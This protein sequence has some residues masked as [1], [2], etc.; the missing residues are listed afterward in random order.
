M[1][2]GL[3]FDTVLHY[4]LYSGVL[5]PVPNLLLVCRQVHSESKSYVTPYT[6]IVMNRSSF[7][8]GI[9]KL[10]YWHKHNLRH[11]T[12]VQLCHGMMHSIEKYRKKGNVGLPT[13]FATALRGR[14]CDVFPALELVLLPNSIKLFSPYHGAAIAFFFLRHGVSIAYI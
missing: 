11:V 13:A 9:T 2:Y 8:V 12:S 10:S 7:N 4:Y 3:A 14:I 1:I 6:A 5:R